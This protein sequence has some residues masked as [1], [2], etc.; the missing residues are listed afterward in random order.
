MI[1]LDE[2]RPMYLLGGDNPKG[3][4]N[5]NL[6]PKPVTAFQSKD[7]PQAAAV[8]NAYWTIHPI[9]KITPETAAKV[10]RVESSMNPYTGDTFR[11]YGQVS[12]DQYSKYYGADSA[13]VVMDEYKNKRR[14]LVDAAADYN[15]HLSQMASRINADNLSFGRVMVNQ[16][17]PNASLD[18]KVSKRVW[19][20]NV[21]LFIKDHRLP[22]TLQ[23]GITTYRDLMN[24]FDTDFYEDG[25]QRPK[26]KPTS[27][28]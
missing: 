21:K 3:N 8:L 15:T 14:T 28:K 13:A 5:K 19:D 4:K 9:D 7:Y 18:Q 26:P 24:A 12:Q 1:H 6:I 11:G 25:S 23:Y 17:A 22:S 10:A 20:N 2:V 27:G 16:F